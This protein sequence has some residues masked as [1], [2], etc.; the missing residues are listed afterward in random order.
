MTKGLQNIL[1]AGM[2]FFL[3]LHFLMVGNYAAPVNM[4]GKLNGIS[5]RYCYPYFH[6]QWTVF[7]PA[8]RRASTL[9]LR[10]KSNNAWQSWTSLT[11]QVAGEAHAHPLKGCETE[12]LLLTNAVSYLVSDLGDNTRVFNGALSLP[13]FQVMARAAIAYYRIR[14][15]Q[16]AERYEL[17][18][19]ISGTGP[20]RCYYFKNLSS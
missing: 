4:G 15:R 16:Y 12:F 17:L 10:A 18:L 6:Q 20:L 2:L 19:V 7:V 13:S 8:P 3:G 1:A 5:S 11:A 14:T 9:Y